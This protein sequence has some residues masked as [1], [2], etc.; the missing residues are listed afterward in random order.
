MLVIQRPVDGDTG[1]FDETWQYPL[2]FPV[3]VM[4]KDS[5]HIPS[6][7]EKFVDQLGVLV[8]T[9]LAMFFIFKM[10]LP[11]RL[12]KHIGEV[13]VIFPGNLIPFSLTLFRER[14]PE[15]GKNNLPAVA[16][17]IAENQVEEI[18]PQV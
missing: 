4:T 11:E 6:L 7:V 9:S 18:C 12:D 17:K 16:W 8:G 15:V 14:I 3:V 2:D 1:M 10:F 5:N 13:P